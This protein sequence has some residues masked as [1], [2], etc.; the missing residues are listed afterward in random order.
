[1]SEEHWLTFVNGC[2]SICRL[3][4]LFPPKWLNFGVTISEEGEDNKE[5]EYD[6]DS[7]EM[8]H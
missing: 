3:S 2:M 8:F 7:Y 6:D 1:M 5:Y 4:D